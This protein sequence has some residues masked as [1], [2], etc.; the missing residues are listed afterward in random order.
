MNCADH[1]AK[2][3]Q[4]G[5]VCGRRTQSNERK[6]VQ[7]KIEWTCESASSA[8]GLLRGAEESVSI[9]RIDSARADDLRIADD[10]LR[11]TA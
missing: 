6:H 11:A 7:L 9:L 8:D 3:L 1:V 5:Q 2:L 10:K 4:P